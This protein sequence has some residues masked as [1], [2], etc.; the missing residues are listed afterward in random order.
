MET[1]ARS[2]SAIEFGC[3]N[4]D[5]GDQGVDP[6]ERRRAQP[7]AQVVHRPRRHALWRRQ[8]ELAPEHGLGQLD[9][10]RDEA[11]A[12][13]PEERAGAAGDDCRR[14][15]G[16][17]AGADRGGEG[18]HERLERRQGALGVRGLAAERGA[19]RLGE[20]DDLDE[21]VADRE[22]QPRSE[23][24]DHDPRHEQRVRRRFD[25][26]RHQMLERP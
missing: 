19:H 20:A 22:E 7:V 12:P 16:D 14:H 6:G 15:A 1:C 26:P 2:T 11:V 24:Q 9:R 10:H 17:V 18:G 21:A 4:G 3:V 8:P 25:P 13:D 23:K 5:A